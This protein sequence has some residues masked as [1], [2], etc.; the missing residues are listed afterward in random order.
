MVRLF[1]II[2]LFFFGCA[3]GQ[4]TTGYLGILETHP[5]IIIAGES[6]AGGIA[7]NTSLTG[8]EAAARTSMEILNNNNLKFETLQMGVNNLLQH[9][10]LT[11]GSTNG[12]THGLE[13][14]LANSADSMKLGHTPAYIVKA[15]LGGSRIMMWVNP[16]SAYTPVN[17]YTQFKTRVD[18]AIKLLTKINGGAPSLYLIWTQGI[19]DS[20]YNYISSD[21]WKD[22]TKSMFAQMRARYGH[23]PIFITK[24]PATYSTYN[25]RIAQI[26]N[27]ISE[28]YV[29]ETSDAALEN[30][31]H[32]SY[33]GFKVIAWRV[34]GLMN[35]NYNLWHN[36]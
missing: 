15:G 33:A 35:A 18:T 13:N 22:S 6:N 20:I 26:A 12:T 2:S 29:I 3:K 16:D 24:L 9:P 8:T 17:G 28:C 5:L 36:Y 34:V 32:W 10:G 14:G 27:E 11:S 7:L 21:V 19:N 31:N 25:L 30:V 4:T 1:L 23:M